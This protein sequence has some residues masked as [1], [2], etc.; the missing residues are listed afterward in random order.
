MTIQRQDVRRTRLHLFIIDR[1]ILAIAL[2]LMERVQKSWYL[3]PIELW[4]PSGLS[5]LAAASSVR[6]LVFTY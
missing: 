2:L 4:K 3:F 5:S 1:T 6:C